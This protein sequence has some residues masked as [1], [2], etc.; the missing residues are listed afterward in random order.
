MYLHRN[1][2]IESFRCQRTTVCPYFGGNL[3]KR[4]YMNYYR[5]RKVFKL[6]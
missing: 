6:S 1:K 2:E 3:W 5:R 4:K